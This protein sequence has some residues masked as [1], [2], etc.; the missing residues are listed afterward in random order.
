MAKSSW[1][2]N[3]NKRPVWYRR[4]QQMMEEPEDE[5]KDLRHHFED[6]LAMFDTVISIA[7]LGCAIWL[8]YEVFYYCWGIFLSYAG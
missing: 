3:P 2:T 7:V 8:L 6:I 4:I 1:K 5:H